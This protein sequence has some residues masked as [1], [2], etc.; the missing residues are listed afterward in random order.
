MNRHQ[1]YHRCHRCH[2]CHLLRPSQP[3]M[4]AFK[5]RYD[6]FRLYGVATRPRVEPT[7]RE[8]TVR[9]PTA[10]E[11][12]GRAPLK[13]SRTKRVECAVCHVGRATGGEDG[14]LHAAQRAAAHNRRGSFVHG[15]RRG[16]SPQVVARWRW[17]KLLGRS[18]RWTWRRYQR[19]YLQAKDD[20]LRQACGQVQ[21]V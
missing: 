12:M 19:F 13:R 15:R 20:N 5:N 11:L 10:R 9:E 8:P 6:L 2:W 18:R 7:V 17:R 4:V 21:G 3:S 14:E 16:G 1:L